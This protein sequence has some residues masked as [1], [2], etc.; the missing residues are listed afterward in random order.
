M[1]FSSSGSPPKDQSADVTVEHV[2]F[3]LA[4]NRKLRNS[5]AQA[6]SPSPIEPANSIRP[7]KAAQLI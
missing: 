1:W 5:F 4:L 6:S 3:K 7:S 2:R